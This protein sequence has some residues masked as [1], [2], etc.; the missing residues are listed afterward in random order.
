VIF[1]RF[2]QWDAVLRLTSEAREHG[3]GGDYLVQHSAVSGKSNTIAWLAH[4][5]SSLHDAADAKVF[6][7]VVVITDRRV[8]DRQL[9]DTIYQFEHAHGVVVRIDEN[10][11]Q[12]ADALA[13]EQA[14]IIITTLQKF[15][16]VTAKIGALPQRRYAVIVDEAENYLALLSE[17]HLFYDVMNALEAKVGDLTGYIMTDGPGG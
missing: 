7:K 11:Q 17:C 15:P 16:F 2:H 8:L 5:L 6:D 1:P 14:R 3:A 9:Q 4:R 10:S 13:G 12:L